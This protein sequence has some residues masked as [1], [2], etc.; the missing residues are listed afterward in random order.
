[1]IIGVNRYIHHSEGFYNNGKAIFKY[2]YTNRAHLY[3][4]DYMMWSYV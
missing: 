4:L 2:Y 3:P 1:M